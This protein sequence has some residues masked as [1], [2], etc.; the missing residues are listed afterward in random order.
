MKH[1]VIIKQW[2]D[3]EHHQWAAVVVSFGERTLEL[4]QRFY[5]KNWCRVMELAKMDPSYKF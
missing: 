4:S 3:K 1:S 5:D 2:Y